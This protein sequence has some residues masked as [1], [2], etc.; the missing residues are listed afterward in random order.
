MTTAGRTKGRTNEWGH[1]DV[2]GRSDLEERLCFWLE[3]REKLGKKT[4]KRS[5][6]KKELGVP[7]FE[8]QRMSDSLQR[9]S[10]THLQRKLT[11]ETWF[12]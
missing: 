11:E 12:Q 9:Q 5:T 4:P 3:I 2:T 10:N 8:H 1:L 6:I 7:D